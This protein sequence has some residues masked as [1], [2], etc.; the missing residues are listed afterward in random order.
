[1][2]SFMILDDR[3]YLKVG[4]GVLVLV[5]SVSDT[6]QN[7][8]QRVCD[9]TS[10]QHATPNQRPA[11]VS[12]LDSLLRDEILWQELGEKGNCNGGSENRNPNLVSGIDALNN[13]WE[14][15]TTCNRTENQRAWD[16]N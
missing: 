12:P 5:F 10:E 13:E 6:V 4:E 14:R 8:S 7:A 11:V 16:A 9:N 1:M 15:F 3:T 2:F